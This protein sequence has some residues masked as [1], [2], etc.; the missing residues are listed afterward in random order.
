VSSRPLVAVLGGG[1][2]G[3]AAAHRLTT[4][5]D[6]PRVVLIE[7]A[8][9]LG[10]CLRGAE[11]D[12]VH[13]DTGPESLLAR[14][15]WGKEL[16]HELGLA[17]DVV[18]PAALGA[19]VWLRGALR[20]LPAGLMTGNASASVVRRS[21]LLTRRG[22]LRAGM[23]LVL[24]GR[25]PK[26]D[27][28]IAQA[29]G[30]RLGS[31]AVDSIAAPLLGGIYAGSV[32]R[33]STQ[34]AAPALAV[35]R[36]RGGS[37]LRALRAGTAPPADSGPVFMSLRGGLAQ[38]PK[39]IAEALVT[40]GAQVRLD[41]RAT[42][43]TTAADGVEISLADGET[44]VADAAVLALPAPG[45]AA[46]LERDA[47]GASA[48]LAAIAHAPVAIATLAF[49]K[50]AI[51]ELPASSGFL[52]ARG[53]GLA[54]SACT[55]SSQKWPELAPDGPLLLRCSI[56]RA[57]DPP[58]LQDDELL[59]LVLRDLRATLGIA[60]A[61]IDARVDRFTDALPQH[62]VGHFER[63]AAIEAEVAAALPRVALAGAWMRGIGLAA[64]IR[65][66]RRA[67]EV[68]MIAARST[69]PGS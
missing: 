37:V 10:G 57:G 22:Q 68:A 67:G 42:A 8:A 36:A 15:P 21:G 64:C 55:I 39:A 18:T 5:P 40:G 33:L 48:T 14:V 6:P 4:L 56:G 26:G 1:I 45:A 32:D 47:P 30:G 61:P 35:A 43:L 65:D 23:D 27:E 9:T 3:L 17:S 69:S 7:A 25:P 60:A 34:A 54:I 28:S 38:L 2:S 16:L 59:E 62:D 41:T 13:V 11:V 44:Q 50:A 58:P 52:V 63:L 24:P 31:E 53:A 66:G 46:L 51:G 19:H 12:G 29:V 20:P 49:D